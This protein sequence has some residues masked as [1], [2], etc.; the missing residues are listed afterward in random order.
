[1]KKKGFTLIELIVVIA[2]LAVLGLLIVPK[3]FGYIEAGKSTTCANNRKLIERAILVAESK[4]VDSRTL[5]TVDA[6]QNVD[7]GLYAGGEVC[8][9]K[10]KI[11]INK[12][13]VYCTIHTGMTIGV[14]IFDINHDLEDL[15][16][17]GDLN[18][19]NGD[20]I[21]WNGTYYI[22]VKGKPNS[23]TPADKAEIERIKKMS[24]EQYLSEYCVKVNFDKYY[25][26]SSGEKPKIGDIRKNTDISGDHY[27]VYYPN[28]S[29]VDD[30]YNWIYIQPKPRKSK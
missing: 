19:G 10:G 25:D 15:S 18:I 2:I 1:M 17:I 16:T 8:P 5:T 3:V 14:D 23:I 7:G 30:R 26:E 13:K 11:A 28:E 24:P 9:D 20:V 12:G 27:F 21:F 6:I 29:N 22:N 4:G